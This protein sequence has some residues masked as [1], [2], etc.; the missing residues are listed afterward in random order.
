[1]PGI[2]RPSRHAGGGCSRGCRVE[3]PA[4]QVRCRVAIR[5]CPALGNLAGSQNAA[6]GLVTGLTVLGKGDS[7]EL[8][9]KAQDQGLDIL[10]VF[11]VEVAENRQDR[12][13][14]Q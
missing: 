7:K 6:G 3:V 12:F 13:D 10:V 4:I 9:E 8:L 1:M 14:R 11:E 5:A 2:R